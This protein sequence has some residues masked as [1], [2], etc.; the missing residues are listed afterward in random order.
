MISP[1]E[2]NMS[3]EDWKAKHAPVGTLLTRDSFYAEHED[4]PTSACGRVG[5]RG[6]AAWRRL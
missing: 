3:F 5:G 1:A 6:G 4:D 2:L